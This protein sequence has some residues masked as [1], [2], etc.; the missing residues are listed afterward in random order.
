MPGTAVDCVGYLVE[1]ALGGMEGDTPRMVST[2][3]QEEPMT[4]AE[5]AE[6]GT[7]SYRRALYHRTGGDDRQQLYRSAA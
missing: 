5:A 1:G 4:P 3:W 2:P 6:I 7:Q